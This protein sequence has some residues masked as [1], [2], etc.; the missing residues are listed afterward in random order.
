MSPLKTPRPDWASLT[1]GQ[2]LV[3]IAHAMQ[4]TAHFFDPQQSADRRRGYHE[5][6][7]LT[8]LTLRSSDQPNRRKELLL[9][10]AFIVDFSMREVPD[11][12]L[13]RVAART[14]LQMNSESYTHIK[15]MGL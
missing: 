5:V 12:D 15:S 6:I 1:F 13:H 9:W 10:R 8:D 3:E 7:E 4:R 11:P 2:Q 14:L